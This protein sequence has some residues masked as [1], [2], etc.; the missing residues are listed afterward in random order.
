[1]LFEHTLTLSCSQS[2]FVI[3]Q[4]EQMLTGMSGCTLQA[5][6]PCNLPRKPN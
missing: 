3:W 4:L 6:L 2:C 1:L 5:K